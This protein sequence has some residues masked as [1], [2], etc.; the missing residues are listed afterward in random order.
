MAIGHLTDEQI[1]VIEPI[2]KQELQAMKSEINRLFMANGPGPQW[3]AWKVR[4]ADKYHR[5]NVL[6]DA[7]GVERWS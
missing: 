6:S 3:D 2:L 1:A 7:L 4:N 5:I